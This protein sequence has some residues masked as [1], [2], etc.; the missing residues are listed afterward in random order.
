MKNIY[1]IKSVLRFL[2]DLSLNNNREWF[3]KNKDRYNKVKEEVET[4][5]L[6]LITEISSF[7][8]RRGAGAGHSVHPGS[9]L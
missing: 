2:S 4:L 3:N 8:H 9:P 6:Q 7:G 1:D 5:T